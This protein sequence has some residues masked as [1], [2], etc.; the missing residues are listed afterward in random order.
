MSFDDVLSAACSGPGRH[1]AWAGHFFGAVA[2]DG[3]CLVVEPNGGMGITRGIM[4]RLSAGTRLVSH[5][6]NVNAVSYFFWVEDGEI[7]LSFESTS[8][9]SWPRPTTSRSVQGPSSRW[10]ST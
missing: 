4:E 6:R 8:R 10:R 5:Y 7:R 9:T 1:G 3:W 2:V